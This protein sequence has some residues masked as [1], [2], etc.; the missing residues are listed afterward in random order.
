[1]TEIKEVKKTTK[2]TSKP[3]K[4]EEVKT[5]IAQEKERLIPLSA[6]SNPC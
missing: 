1:M 3:K 5:E 2:K 6:V 4:V